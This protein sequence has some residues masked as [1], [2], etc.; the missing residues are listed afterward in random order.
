MSDT[1]CCVKVHQT[2]SLTHYASYLYVLLTFSGPIAEGEESIKSDL[3]SCRAK[4]LN[5]NNANY[6]QEL[7]DVT[8]VFNKRMK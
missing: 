5:P 6:L 4:F 2:M 3:F 7:F 1:A 8:A